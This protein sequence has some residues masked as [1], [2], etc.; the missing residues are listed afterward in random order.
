[1]VHMLTLEPTA[2]YSWAFTVARDGR[3]LSALDIS[4]WRERGDLVVEGEPYRIAREGL[5]SGD[6][7]LESV[8]GGVLATATKPSILC[9]TFRVSSGGRTLTLRPRS[10]WGRALVVRE[11]DRDVG[12]ITPRG[13][14]THR[15]TAMLP[16]DLPLPVQTFLLWLAVL[17]WKRESD[18]GGASA[19]VSA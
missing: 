11:G 12:S 7:R 13:V 6:F 17:I 2:W 1:M 4:T 18:S 16:D 10:I 14:W 15:A 19:A 8:G 5:C 9:R 3:A